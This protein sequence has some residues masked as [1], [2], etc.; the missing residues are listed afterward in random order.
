[1]GNEDRHAPHDA[2]AIRF[3]HQPT[4]GHSYIATLMHARSPGYQMSCLRNSSNDP[5]TRAHQ[6]SERCRM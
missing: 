2:N 4:S 5:H 3:R 1:M 6:L